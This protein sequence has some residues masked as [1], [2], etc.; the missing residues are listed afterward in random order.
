MGQRVK[1]V[2]SRAPLQVVAVAGLLLLLWRVLRGVDFSLV[3]LR[4][5]FSSNAPGLPQV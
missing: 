5:F 2:L 4:L 1:R 3:F